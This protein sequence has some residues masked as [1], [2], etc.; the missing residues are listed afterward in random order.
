MSE[1]I[2][3][4]LYVLGGFIFASICYYKNPKSIGCLFPTLIVWPVYLVIFPFT[5]FV[6]WWGKQIDKLR[7]KGGNDER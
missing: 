7:E 4:S 3:V 2:A 1:V 6:M 5:I